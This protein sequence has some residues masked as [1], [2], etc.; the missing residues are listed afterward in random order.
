MPSTAAI[1][2][3]SNQPLKRFVNTIRLTLMK[4]AVRAYE[5]YKN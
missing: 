1:R 5:L 2:S 4:I 3:S